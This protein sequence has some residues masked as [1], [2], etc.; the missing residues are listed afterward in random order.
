MA[1]LDSLTFAVDIPIL[2]V[3]KIH[4]VTILNLLR[5]ILRLYSG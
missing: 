2:L 1:V 3:T 4:V 5:A